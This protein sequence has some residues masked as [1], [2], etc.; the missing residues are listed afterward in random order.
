MLVAHYLACGALPSYTSKFSR[1]DFTLPQLFACLCGKTLLKRSYREAEAVLRDAPHWCHAVGMRKVPDHNTL[2]R[3]AAA[4]LK[5]CNV[6]RLLDAV[7]RW[8]ALHRALGLSLK[9]LA[10]DSSTFEHHH[11]SRH[12]ENR[13]RR[14]SR[15]ARRRRMAGKKR[16]PARA[17]RRLPK[18]GI[19]VATYS[20]L[21]LSAW[22]GTGSGSDCPHFERLLFDA[23][24]R[25]PHR[26]F[27]AV[28]DA[29]YD[30][31]DNHRIA[32]HDMGLR[33]IIPPLIGRPSDK[34]PTYWRRRMKRMLRSKQ[35]RRRCGY[36]QRW[37]A[38]TVVSMVKRNLGSALAGKTTNSRKRDMLLKVLTHD[39]MIIRRRRRVETEQDR[40]NY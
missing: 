32:R 25:V 31:E 23:W 21:A 39:V 12:F 36:T 24:R 18:L 9:P 20:H 35:S 13:R 38:E 33:S 22:C 6:S 11:V 15:R 29:G 7:A 4:L 2:C 28:F 1:H 3:A 17:L 37:Q 30:S 14:E 8:A 16:N 34:P 40:S 10:G 19:A 27:T 26:T 5:R